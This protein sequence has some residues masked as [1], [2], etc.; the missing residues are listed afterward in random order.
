MDRATALRK[1]GKI[2]GKSFRYRIDDKAPTQEQREVARAALPAATT[3]VNELKAQKEARYEAI[4]AAD[5]EYQEL[6]L[7]LKEA[8]T[9]RDR[10]SG[11]LHYYKIT[12][13][14]IVAGVLFSVKAQ[15]DTWDE[16]VAKLTKEKVA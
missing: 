8:Q 16:V 14:V 9:K 13:G 6:K 4:L 11:T 3:V 7:A 15:G 5:A 1:L 2:L 10:L 12:V